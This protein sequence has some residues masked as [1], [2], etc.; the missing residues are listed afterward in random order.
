MNTLINAFGETRRW[1]KIVAIFLLVGFALQII[2]TLT[3]VV[4]AGMPA[5]QLFGV[6]MGILCYLI[7]GIFLLRY[8]KAVA[9]AEQSNNPADLEAACLY[10]GRYFKLLG[11]ITIIAII[12]GVAG[13]FLVV[14]AGLAGSAAY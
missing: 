4:G 13:A 14:G 8:S 11:I 9:Q 5:Q 10:Q 12:L 3:L 7:P 1:A 6:I 2:Q